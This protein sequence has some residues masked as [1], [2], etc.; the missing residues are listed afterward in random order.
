MAGN[1]CMRVFFLFPLG[2]PSFSLFFP[3]TRFR[4]AGRVGERMIISWHYPSPFFSLLDSLRGTFHSL[5]LFLPP[6]AQNKV[7]RISFGGVVYLFPSFFF[8]FLRSRKDRRLPLCPW[9]FRP[10]PSFSLFLQISRFCLS[11][12]FFCLL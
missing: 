3:G 1:P 2:R 5:L 11:P 6:P 12:L 9:R 4:P 8:F 7:A 10:V